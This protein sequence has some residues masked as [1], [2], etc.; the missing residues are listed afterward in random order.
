M[1]L[2]QCV[3]CFQAASEGTVFVQNNPTIR[4]ADKNLNG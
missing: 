4:H 2:G 3:S 1:H